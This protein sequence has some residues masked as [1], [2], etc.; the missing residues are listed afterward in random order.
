MAIARHGAGRPLTEPQ[1]SELRAA[2]DYFAEAAPKHTA[3]EE[4]SVFP[5]LRR[6]KDEAAEHALDLVTTLEHDHE[7]A[8]A[9]HRAIDALGRRWLTAGQLTS[10]DIHDFGNR[11]QVLQ[12]IYGRHI[13][14]EDRELFPAAAR[15]LS[16]EELRSIGREMAARR[17][18]LSDR[19]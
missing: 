8:D 10:D 3:D 6:S 7:E 19:R 13:A 2:L 4:E 5:R 9:H 12:A 14:I 11:L 18:V 15:L 1:Q 16:P 17:G